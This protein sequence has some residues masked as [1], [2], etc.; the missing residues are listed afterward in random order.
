MPFTPGAGGLYGTALT[1]IGLAIE[2]SRGTQMSEPAFLFPVLGPKYDLMQAEILN[3]SI[4]G[5]MVD[6]IDAIDGMRYDKHGW[7]A[8]P[9]LDSFPIIVCAE[10][11][12]TDTLTTAPTSTTLASSCT[13]GS[14]TVS[15]TGIV[16]AGDF[17]V[18]DASTPAIIEAHK[19]ASVTGLG[20]YTA[21]LD[22]PTI[23]P[24]ANAA[25]V[26]GLTGHTFSVLNTGDGEPPSLSL[27]DN[28]GE[29][30]R[31]MA[32]CQLNGLNIKGNASDLITYTT[33]LLGNA[34]VRNASAPSTSW[35]TTEAPAQWT[36]QAALGGTYIQTTV[37]WEFDLTRDTKEVP[38]VTGQKGYFRYYAAPLKSTAKWTFL[39]QS[40]SPYLSDYEQGL[41]ESFDLTFFDLE[42]GF[43]CNI[44]SSSAKFTSGSLGRGNKD[45]WVTV[46]MDVQL[47]PTSSDA[48]AGGTSPIKITIANASASAVH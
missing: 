24:H 30:W 23:Y 22:Y 32:A 44:H 7:D 11:G 18:L 9:F 28:D 10:L 8:Y 27:W 34:A 40:G 3:K 4:Q 39:E 26:T 43:L 31:T 15:I 17:I 21:T 14:A 12:S 47:L 20:P 45:E 6:T 42:S 33:D 1:E 19:I 36:V 25:T 13:A 37:D 5:V 46:P 48:T 41:K 2:T 16:A 38:A 35:T 29:E